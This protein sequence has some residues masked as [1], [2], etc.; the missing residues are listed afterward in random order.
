VAPASRSLEHLLPEHHA[1]LLVGRGLCFVT[2]LF[3]SGDI[4]PV[5]TIGFTFRFAQPSIVVA[6]LLMLS[7]RE[8]K[9]RPHPGVAWLY[10]FAL[11]IAVT[12]PF[13]LL[14]ERSLAYVLWTITDILIIATLVQYFSTPGRLLQLVRWYA[15]GFIAISWFGVLQFALGIL[16]VSVLVTEWWIPDVLPR[17]NGISYEPSYYAT[18]L[19]AGW[20]FACFLIE[21]KATVPSRRLQWLCMSSTTV[22]LLLCASRM[23]WLFMALW[24]IFRASVRL[25][26]VLLH[27]FFARRSLPRY[28]GASA[29]L[30]LLGVVLMHYQHELGAGLSELNFL[31]QG[32]GLFGGASSS[33]GPRLEG[34]AWTWRSFL[35]HPI[36]GSGIGALPVQIAQYAGGAVF[37]PTD[38]KAYEGMSTC[39]ELLASTGIVGGLLIT[40]F[41][42]SVIRSYKAARKIAEAA[43]RKLLSA[44]G[45]AVIWLVLMLQ[46]N[47]N[48]L[49]IYLYVD[50]G[51]L[52]CCI[53][54]AFECAHSSIAATSAL[55]DA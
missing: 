35:E 18:Y 17:I 1:A 36:L 46:F 37:S 4:W 19:I 40:G 28:L 31:M 9:I 51:V 29:T 24:I 52:I 14:F 43:H 45:W 25:L 23:G 38:A 16:G 7:V 53:I 34:L 42:I 41:A 55:E 2:I 39:V 54:V 10:G 20:V 5:F 21:T 48:F 15:V 11:W 27:G 6:A 22:A 33:S 50:L 13:S 26:H 3:A 49:R 12:L 30:S 44:L 47:Q 8:V 32:L